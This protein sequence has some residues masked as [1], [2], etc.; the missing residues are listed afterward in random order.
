MIAERRTH[1]ITQEHQLHAGYAAG[2]LI[3]RCDSPQVCWLCCACERVEVAMG[4]F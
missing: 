3:L 4:E 1:R 2:A